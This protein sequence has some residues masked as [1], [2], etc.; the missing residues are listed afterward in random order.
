MSFW[1]SSVETDFSK[2]SI[3][4]PWSVQPTLQRLNPEF[5]C[6]PSIPPLGVLFLTMQLQALFFLLFA[7][8][9]TV[10]AIPI[11][12][13]PA[14]LPSVKGIPVA[15]LA[16]RS[17]PDIGKRAPLTPSEVDTLATL[18]EYLLPTLGL[19]NIAAKDVRSLARALASAVANPAS[20]RDSLTALEDMLAETVGPKLAKPLSDAIRSLSKG[21]LL[22]KLLPKLVKLAP[23]LLP[24]RSKL[25]RPHQP[26]YRAMPMVPL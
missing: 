9:V 20:T 1:S 16:F 18:F 26:R 15:P 24:S 3:Y 5:D 25:P 21:P 8:I 22:E 23:H 2:A 6:P 13:P 12:Q 14:H 19:P 17:V 4:K 11:E 10:H 7:C